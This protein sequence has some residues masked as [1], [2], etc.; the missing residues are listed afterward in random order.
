MR[1]WTCRP[2]VSS[3]PVAIRN[4]RSRNFAISASANPRP[5]WPKNCSTGSQRKLETDPAMNTP[6]PDRQTGEQKTAR[7]PVKIIPVAPLKKPDWIRVKAPGSE[8]F[9]EIKQALREHKLHTVC[10]EASC[11]NIGE[12][13]G[14]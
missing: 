9:Y 8:R 2:S 3:T 13:F 12:C 4:W 10:E 6:Q 5:R 14:K 1:T 11:P 7:N